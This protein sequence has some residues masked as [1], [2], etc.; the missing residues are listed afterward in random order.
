[1]ATT[2]QFLNLA[3]YT[4][5]TNDRY[6]GSTSG[7]SFSTQITTMKNGREKRVP[8][9]TEG[10]STFEIGERD[11]LEKDY[12]KLY[13]FFMLCNGQ[14]TG[15]RFRDWTDYKDDGIG[16]LLP[17]EINS[18]SFQ[19]YKKRMIEY[20]DD[21]YYLQK[22]RRPI[23]P[24]FATRAGLGNTIKFYWNG[25]QVPQSDQS[26][27]KSLLLDDKKGIAKFTSFVLLA[28]GIASNV[29]AISSNPNLKIGDGIYFIYQTKT[30]YGEITNITNTS[31]VFK[32]ADSQVY[33]IN[34]SVELHPYPTTNSDFT[35]TGEFD[36][37]V[38]F[39]TDQWPT[40]NKIFIESNGALNPKIGYTIPS[41]Q[42]KEIIPDENI[43]E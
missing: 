27:S 25:Q 14:A 36:K 2:K 43:D 5:S 20:I 6:W 42:F 28:S 1:M 23:G 39:A 9:L 38:R 29:A 8:L 41:L 4:L 11:I 26:S 40:T 21:E 37:P 3:R 22:I 35:W 34:T 33:D 7:S 17:I 10:L 31:L 13:N 19:M 16:V 30:I 12:N 32:T 15:F 24:S 18:L